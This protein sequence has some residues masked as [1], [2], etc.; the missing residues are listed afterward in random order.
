MMQFKNGHRVVED[1]HGKVSLIDGSGEAVVL[2]KTRR[3][4]MFD[5]S[6]AMVPI[7]NPQNYVQRYTISPP[8]EAMWI[9]AKYGMQVMC[10]CGI[11]E[12][13]AVGE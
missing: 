1:Q 7:D 6:N 4:Q 9:A 13:K 2:D 10:D 5:Q 8:S 3:I 11:F 12:V